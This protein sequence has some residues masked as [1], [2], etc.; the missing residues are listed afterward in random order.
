MGPGQ[1]FSPTLKS[2]IFRWLS[3]LQCFLFYVFF[4]SICCLLVNVMFDYFIVKI[5]IN[6]LSFTQ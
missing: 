1:L 5:I 2:V 3:P 6:K 4:Q